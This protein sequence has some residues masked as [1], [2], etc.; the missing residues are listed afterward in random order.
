[1]LSMAPDEKSICQREAMRHVEKSMQRADALQTYAW[2]VAIFMSLVATA[3]I[4]YG[5]VVL[6][7]NNDEYSDAFADR[8]Q[9]LTALSFFVGGLFGFMITHYVFLRLSWY[10]DM[11]R[12][13]GHQLRLQS[14]DSI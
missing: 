2:V 13:S 8:Y 6:L 1:M 11:L 12:T 7:A 4:V 3:N 9:L 10:A 5:F 14:I